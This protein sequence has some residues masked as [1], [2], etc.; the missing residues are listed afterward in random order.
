[1]IKNLI[2]DIIT[3]P[4]KSNRGYFLQ[5]ILL[6]GGG[7]NTSLF[8]EIELMLQHDSFMPQVGL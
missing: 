5:S 8:F 6:A 3:F 2:N 1:M 4:V 7:R